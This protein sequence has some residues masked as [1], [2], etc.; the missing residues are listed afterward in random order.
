MISRR[1]LR[2]LMASAALAAAVT[3]VGCDTDGVMLPSGR[4]MAPLSDKMLAEIEAK[5]M[6]KESPILVRLFK[7]ESELEVWKQDNTGRFALLKTYPICRWSGELGPK[8]K[9]GDRQAPEGFYTITPGLMNPNSNYYLAIN[10][11]FPNAYDRANGRTGEFLMIHGDCSSAGCYAMT[12]EQIAEIYALA[13][14]SFL[15]GQ[16]SFQ[17]Q[18]FPFRMTPLNMAKHRD[19][20]N[21]P[22]WKM[23]KEGYDHFEVTHLEPKVDVCDK[24]YVFD[25]ETPNGP[26]NA[27]RFNPTAKC[28][29]YE[30]PAEIAMPVKE[31]QKRDEIELASLISRGTPTVPVRTGTDG[32][33]NP[34][35]MAAVVAHG[36]TESRIEASH[37]LPGSIPANIRPPGEPSYEP[38]TTGSTSTMSLASTESRPAPA[39]R[40]QVASAGPSGGLFSGLFSTK[41]D[42]GKSGGDSQSGSSG[43]SSGNVF[44]RLFGSQEAA[45]AAPPSAVKPKPV[46]AKPTQTASAAP[47]K[48]KTQTEAKAAKPAAEPQPQPSQAPAETVAPAETASNVLRGAQPTVP[49]GSFDSRWSAMR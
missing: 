20:P 49:A 41:D 5:N 27:V 33:M 16:K 22:F 6:T 2:T 43:G 32:G 23:I 11:G 34:I 8:I 37:S 26:A 44:T 35:F 10:T 19:S 47:S 12:D 48:P 39:P 18:A 42:S 28:P 14:E 4:A 31:K 25:A 1:L 30:V 46:A 24:H 21:M 17:I 7:E 45:E 3:L 29:A 38:A 36:G 40:A 15:G 9:L 13:R